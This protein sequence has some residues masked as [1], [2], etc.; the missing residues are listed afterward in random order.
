MR[1]HGMG[2]LA[3]ALGLL[4]LGAGHL[5]AAS[6]APGLP[7]LLS[8]ESQSRQFVVQGPPEILPSPSYINDERRTN[9]VLLNQANL[10][11]WAER[12]KQAL[13]RELDSPDGWRGRIF[14]NLYR[15]ADLGE[16]V[17]VK[18]QY[19]PQGW[20]YQ[21]HVPS[22][23][24]PA[25]LNR[26][27]VAVLLQEMADRQAGA[28]P[29]ELPPWLARGMDE[30]LALRH[31]ASFRVVP[32]AG[33]R[34]TAT[35]RVERRVDPVLII[36]QRLGGRQPL[37]LDELNWPPAPVWNEPAGGFYDQ[38]SHLFVL[39]LL[40]LPEGPACLRRFLQ[41]QAPRHLNWQTGFLQA[42][43]AHFKN[44]RDVDKWWNVQITTVTGRD[45]ANLYSLAE[46]WRKLEEILACP[47]QIKGED[48]R[49]TR[50]TVSL[51]TVIDQ[52]EV[53]RQRALL[54]QKI[55][56]LQLLRTRV[57]PPLLRL[58]EDYL[59]VLQN[60]LSRREK[61]TFAADAQA[62]MTDNPRTLARRTV[63]QLDQLDIV[64]ADLKTATP[65]TPSSL[66]PPQAAGVPTL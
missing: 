39:S 56:Q 53:G 7:K 17:A 32:D 15:A 44:M 23:V 58:T 55:G 42:F 18:A 35:V 20:F 24:E 51:Q 6:P 11:V 57:A 12:V 2:W 29:P 41:E 61:A 50:Q 43:A 52:W 47:V 62:M 4:L 5:Q 27:L 49:L 9:Y 14:I 60:Y 30:L 59:R 45:Q 16:P 54:R 48:G 28:H 13:L 66:S 8:I 22:E 63:A 10:A 21:M 64:R 26:A 25:R 31:G 34:D 38:C 65:N 33:R 1:L 36:R 46:S 40:R 37:T 3:S 19:T